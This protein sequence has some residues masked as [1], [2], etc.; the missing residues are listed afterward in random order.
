MSSVAQ[1]PISMSSMTVDHQL[2]AFVNRPVPQPLDLAAV[3]FQP[4]GNR[5]RVTLARG[6][7]ADPDQ[8]LRDGGGL[9]PGRELSEASPA[10][11]D[12]PDR[13]PFL[14]TVLHARLRDGGNLLEAPSDVDADVEAR[15]GRS[16]AVAGFSRELL[17]GRLERGDGVGRKPR[18]PVPRSGAVT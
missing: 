9:Q 3:T 16:R 14:R 12:A 18:S 7:A 15:A 1:S 13:D 17:F 6:L 10:R 5:P 4:P 2:P 11:R 8:R